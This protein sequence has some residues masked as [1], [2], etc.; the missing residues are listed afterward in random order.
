MISLEAF[1]LM[2]EKPEAAHATAFLES[3]FRAIGVGFHPDT[4]FHDYVDVDTGEKLFR[5]DDADDLDRELAEAVALQNC[6][7]EDADDVCTRLAQEWYAK[8]QGDDDCE[9]PII[10]GP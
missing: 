9:R 5:D 8:A 10:V 4:S 1:E 3:A 6:E 7:L 2:P